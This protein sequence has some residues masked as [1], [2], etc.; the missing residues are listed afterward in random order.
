VK[1]VVVHDFHDIRV[2][3]RPIPDIGPGELLVK[4]GACGICSGDI[5]PW[6]IRKKAPLVLGHEPAGVVHQVGSEGTGFSVGDR[7]FVHHHAPCFQCA[8]CDKGNYTMCETWRKSRIEPGGMAEYFRVPAENLADTL[9]LPAEVS[10]E[11]GVLIEPVACGVKAIRRARI[12]TGDKVLVI[13]LGVMGQ[14]L[15]KLAKLAG[16]AEVVASDFVLERR[17]RALVNGADI[18]VDPRE[19]DLI[20]AVKGKSERKADVVIVGPPSIE[21]MQQG[22]LCVEK[23]GTLLLFTPT[24]PG[25][26]LSLAPYDIYFN[27]VSIVPSYSCGPNDTREALKLFQAGSLKPEDFISERYSVE[28]APEAFR[29]MASG[30]VLKAVVK[31]ENYG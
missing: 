8:H 30:E 18:V 19:E 23:G 4:A 12:Q 25:E 16:A 22:L 21:A 14:I 3:D 17:Q 9:L 28:A 7:V 29:A 24:P 27:E 15:I 26:I 6:Y 31:F 10:M 5:M 11:A 2:E 13:G 20:V 1:A